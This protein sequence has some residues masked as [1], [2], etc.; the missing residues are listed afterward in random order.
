M[1]SYPISQVIRSDLWARD[2]DMGII[3]AITVTNDVGV[4]EECRVGLGKRNKDGILGRLWGCRKE[5]NSSRKVR[6]CQ[7]EKDKR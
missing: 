2:E 4:E 3:M 6:S 1:L 7:R 5:K